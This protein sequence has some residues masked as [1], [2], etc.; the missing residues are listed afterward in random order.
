[1]WAALG[2]EVE[3]HL[4]LAALGADVGPHLVLAA[5]GADAG[6]PRLATLGAEM[7]SS[8]SG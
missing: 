8:L 5:L 1:M 2:V 7:E 4:M 6:F 3:P